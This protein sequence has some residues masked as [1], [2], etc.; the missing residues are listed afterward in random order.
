[1][2][3]RLLGLLQTRM[4]RTRTMKPTTPP[5]V[6]YCVAFELVVASGAAEQRA[7]RQR[8]R[9]AL[10][11]VIREDGNKIVFQVS[12]SRETGLLKNASAGEND[13]QQLPCNDGDCGE[14]GAKLSWA[15]SSSR[16]TTCR[17]A[18]IR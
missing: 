13:R 7:A 14:A 9:R 15:P 2:I 10:S 1:M 18:I 6:P 17:D 16:D 11:M 3:K 8:W 4:S 12:R 5:P